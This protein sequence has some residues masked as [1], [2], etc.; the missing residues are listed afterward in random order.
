[1]LQVGDKGQVEAK[2]F[3]AGAYSPKAYH[4]KQLERPCG[5]RGVSRV[6]RQLFHH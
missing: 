4:T 2:K 1:M 3:L 5:R 6:E